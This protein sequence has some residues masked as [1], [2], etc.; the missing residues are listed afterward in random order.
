MMKSGRQGIWE[1]KCFFVNFRNFEACMKID[2]KQFAIFSSS[3]FGCFG[4]SDTKVLA[5]I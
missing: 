2:K 3:K 1:G 5:K 4:V